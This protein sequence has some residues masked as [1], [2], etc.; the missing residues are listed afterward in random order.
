[1][2]KNNIKDIFESL[3]DDLKKSLTYL[4]DEKDNIVSQLRKWNSEISY[5]ELCESIKLIEKHIQKWY[6]NYLVNKSTN[7]IE[8]S[9]Y[10]I[11]SKESAYLIGECSLID[12]IKIE[13]IDWQ[14]GI[15]G[16][17]IVKSIRE[18]NGNNGS[19]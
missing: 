8:L 12:G 2:E 11:V 5:D 17:G 14:I 1:M 18:R 19:A 13:A 15:I 16:D 3:L 6:K 7:I 9:D 10:Q 4:T